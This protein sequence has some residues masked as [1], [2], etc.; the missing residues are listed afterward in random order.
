MIKKSSKYTSYSKSTVP[1]VKKTVAR[2]FPW[3]HSTGF[4]SNLNLGKPFVFSEIDPQE[5]DIFVKSICAM[6][7]GKH[8][9]LWQFLTMQNCGHP[10][11][12]ASSCSQW[13]LLSLVASSSQCT[14]SRNLSVRFSYNLRTCSM[15]SF[16]S[17]R[18]SVYWDLKMWGEKSVPSNFPPTSHSTLSTLLMVTVVSRGIV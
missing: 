7:C 11:D 12:L 6:L 5:F 8:Q 14:H 3:R 17:K 9:P 18:V 2:A 1:T 16:I 4:S 15:I 13:N 10:R